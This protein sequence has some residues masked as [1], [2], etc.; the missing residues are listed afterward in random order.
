MLSVLLVMLLGRVG[1][2]KKRTLTGR[3]I[4][5]TTSLGL[6]APLCCIRLPPPADHDRLE[7]E[8]NT[9]KESAPE[10]MTNLDA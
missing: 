2:S 9:E 5:P 6:E 4:D 8:I 10:L 7:L 3:S 1:D